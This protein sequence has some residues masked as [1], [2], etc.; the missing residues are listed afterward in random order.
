M[1]K[2]LICPLAFPRKNDVPCIE[3]NCAFWMDKDDIETKKSDGGMT[4]TPVGDCAVKIIA[5]RI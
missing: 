3:E 5:R 4:H 2:Q 1:P